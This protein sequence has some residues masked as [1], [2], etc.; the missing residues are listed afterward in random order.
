MMVAE[1][2]NGSSLPHHIVHDLCKPQFIHLCTHSFP[3][4]CVLA[5]SHIHTGE[6]LVHCPHKHICICHSRWIDLGLANM[7]SVTNL[8][9]V[10]SSCVTWKKA[11]ELGS[12]GS[13]LTSLLAG[14]VDNGITSASYSLPP[15][16]MGR[17]MPASQDVE[18]FVCCGLMVRVRVSSFQFTWLTSGP[19][20]LASMAP[21]GPGLFLSTP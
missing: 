10:L 7:I 12:P 4:C 18:R 17:R 8:L 5:S 11:L 1:I 14:S 20:L 2:H 13:S 9:Q 6:W 16:N 15:S 21:V 19:A 3:E